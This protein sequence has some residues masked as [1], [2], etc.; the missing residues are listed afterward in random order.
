MK[1]DKPRQMYLLAAECAEKGKNYAAAANDYYEA[2][3]S[4]YKLHIPEKSDKDFAGTYLRKALQCADSAEDYPAQQTTKICSALAD[5]I[6]ESK[7]LE[8]YTLYERAFNLC[9]KSDPEKAELTVI[10]SKMQSRLPSRMP[11]AK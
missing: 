9:S 10:L 11:T 6:A 4:R 2:A 5:Q 1:H 7:P 3:K 8:A